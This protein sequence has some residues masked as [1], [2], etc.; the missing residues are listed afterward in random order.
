MTLLTDALRAYIGMES[1]VELACD[2]VEGGAVRR[3]AQAIMD[4][5]PMFIGRG[6][7]A[8]RYGGAVA[9]MLFPTHQFRRAFG[10]PDP[11]QANANNLDFDGIADGVGATATQ[12]LPEILPLKG[13]RLMNGGSE[14]EFF[15]YA[16]HGERV[17]VRSRYA[18]IVER[19]TSK[20]PM[21]LV[22]VESEFRTDA[23]ELLLKL[24]TSL[25][26]R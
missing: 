3:Y 8:A 18:D 14:F 17:T 7:A 12:G 4:D 13:L 5:D 9:P 11:I 21:V 23:G 22:T 19:E 24:Q 6:S 10:T 25:I 1:S 15:R 16:K 2:P 26:R 20:G